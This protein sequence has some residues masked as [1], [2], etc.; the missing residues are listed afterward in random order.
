M[1]P[2]EKL[3]RTRRR[4]WDF[5]LERQAASDEAEHVRASFD[6]LRAER[7]SDD[8][9]GG[10]GGGASAAGPAGCPTRFVA[11]DDEG[12]LM[13]PDLPA[14]SW[15]GAPRKHALQRASPR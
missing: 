11:R 15:E 12:Y 3:Y 9:G 8:G 14:R 10:G 7:S 5:I 6:A 4:L 1:K 13:L 2:Q